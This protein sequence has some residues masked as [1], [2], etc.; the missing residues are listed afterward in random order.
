LSLY[1]SLEYYTV[2][3]FKF[4]KKFCGESLATNKNFF[5][6]LGP[7]ASWDIFMYVRGRTE[8]YTV[9]DTVIYPKEDAGMDAKEG[10]KM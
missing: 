2:E 1:L 5:L 9:M 8:L 10:A 6:F 3:S 4:I 7:S